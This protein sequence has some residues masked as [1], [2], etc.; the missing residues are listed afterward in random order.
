MT[1]IHLLDTWN[2]KPGRTAHG[3]WI[4]RPDRSSWFWS[5]NLHR[6]FFSRILFRYFILWRLGWCRGSLGGRGFLDSVM[7]VP[8]AWRVVGGSGAF[9]GARFFAAGIPW[10][11][12]NQ[13]NDIINK[14]Y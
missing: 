3:G 9:W 2:G 13:L 1:L 5:I 10:E 11:T 14:N 6:F 4:R 12:G 8:G 7:S